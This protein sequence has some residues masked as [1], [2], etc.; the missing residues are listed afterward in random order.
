MILIQITTNDMM[1]LRGKFVVS[2]RTLSII[3]DMAF[4]GGY[5]RFTIDVIDYVKEPAQSLSY[6]EEWLNYN[7]FR[8]EN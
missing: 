2:E 4:I 6:V 1:Q 3:E 5:L 7:V 8:Y